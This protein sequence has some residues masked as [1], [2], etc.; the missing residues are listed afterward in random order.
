MKKHILILF[1]LIFLFASCKKMFDVKYTG[2]ITG[3]DVS[4]KVYEDPAFINS[5]I[6]G[7][8]SWGVKLDVMGG[9]GGF[10][11]LGVVYNTDMMGVDIAINGTWTWG[12]FDINHDIG[13]STHKRP[14]QFWNF[15]YTLINKAN[16]VIDIFKEE[17]SDE[18]LR[19]CLGAAYALRAFAYTYLMHL[20]QDP[21][22]GTSPNAKF[23]DSAPGVPII[24][25][26]RDGIKDSEAEKRAGRN[27]LADIKEEIERNLELAL[28]LLKGTKRLM[29]NEVNYE[30]AQG[31]AA[32]YYLLTLQWDKALAAAQ[33]AQNGFDLMDNTRLHSGF[34]DI[35]DAEVMWGFEHTV[36]TSTWFASFF[37]HLSNDSPGYGGD[38]TSIHCIDRS[39]YDKIPDT[40]YRKTLF[41]SEKGDPKADKVGARHPYAARKF[42]WIKDWLQHYIYMRKAEMILIEAEAHARLADG[43]ATATLARLMA[44]RDPAWSGSNVTLDDVLLQRRIELWGEGF[45]YYDI[46]RNGLSVNR[47]YSGTNHDVAAQYHFPAHG[48]SWNFQIPLPEIQRNENISEDEQNEWITGSDES[49]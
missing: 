39:L 4:R 37:S 20:F 14:Y 27:T 32:R 5:F 2:N 42:G 19:G 26:K 18:R 40:D 9:H 31:I 25:A 49:I 13:S 16:K 1:S 36:K 24:Y 48:K 44:K 35:N 3:S 8:Y 33:A 30:V 7:C 41:N 29:K 46:R 12:K 43:Q 17:P 28:P 47:K 6:N 15:Y 10:G 21:I 23:R 34:M 38:G 45:E 11:L 22:E